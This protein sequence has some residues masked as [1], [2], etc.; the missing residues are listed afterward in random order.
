VK[1]ADQ[2]KA[3]RMGYPSDEQ[4]AYTRL[5]NSCWFTNIEHGRRHE[6]MQLMTMADNLKFNKKLINKLDGGTDYVR[7]DNYDAIEVP[8]SDAIPSDYDGVMG[9]PITWL[10][11]YN[12]DQFEIIGTN[13]YTTPHGMS[14]K[15][16][17][18]YYASGQKGQISEGHP[19]LCY[20]AFHGRPVVTYDR[21]LIRHRRM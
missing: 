12:P 8:F 9:V 6:P 13:R 19:D 7:Y 14:Q 3:E 18:D 4:Y 1:P 11:K 15:F 5:G 2:A 16:V 21:I 20:Y 17:D 10:D